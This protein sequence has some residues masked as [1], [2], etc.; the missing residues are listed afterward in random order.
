M[1]EI[2]TLAAPIDPSLT[3]FRVALIAFDWQNA[4]IK[5][6]VR[7]W[8]GSAFGNRLVVAQYSG[9]QATALM[10]ALNKANLSTN[11]LNQ[12]VIAQLLADGKLPTGTPSGAPD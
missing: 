12:R 5:V 11:S 7:D 1:A 6:H 4:T 10:I 3:V 2:V 8:N 9:A